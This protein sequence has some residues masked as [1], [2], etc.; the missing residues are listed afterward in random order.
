[1]NEDFVSF[2]LAKKLKEKGF[3]EECLANYNKNGILSYNGFTAD[4]DEYIDIPEMLAIHN[5]GDTYDAPTITQV[6]TWL[7]KEYRIYIGLSPQ[8]QYTVYDMRCGPWI[9]RSDMQIYDDDTKAIIA[10][11]EYCL[12]NLI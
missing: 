9:G 8:W 3:R 12:D 10:G 11:I 7:R 2:E 6:W 1:M 4:K 5:Y